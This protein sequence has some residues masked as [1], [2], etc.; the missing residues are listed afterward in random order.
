METGCIFF[1][2]RTECLSITQMSFGFKGLIEI[3][4]VVWNVMHAPEETFDVGRNGPITLTSIPLIRP[5]IRNTG[6][7]GPVRPVR[8]VRYR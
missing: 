4:R 6:R 3:C 2:A 8:N 5:S 7:W 1:E